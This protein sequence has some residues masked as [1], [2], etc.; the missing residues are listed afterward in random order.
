[1]DPMTNPIEQTLP[2]VAGEVPADWLAV[3]LAELHEMNSDTWDGLLA[4]GIQ[5]GGSLRIEFA[6]TAPNEEQAGD[7]ADE[8]LMGEYDSRAA[9]PDSELDAWTVTGT[10]GEVSVTGRGQEE[11][12]RR[13]VATGWQHGESTLDGWS[14]VLE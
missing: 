14:A 9:P 2:P 10:T 7:L 4:S 6:F 1:M 11:W 12:L 5:E 3:N 8:L 13:M